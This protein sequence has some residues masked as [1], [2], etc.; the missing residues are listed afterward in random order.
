MQ[1]GSL[2]AQLDDNS[3]AKEMSQKSHHNLG[4]AYL[5]INNNST[6]HFPYYCDI[7]CPIFFPLFFGERHIG[8]SKC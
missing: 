4:S 8:G 1:D 2:D 6:V 3:C 5:Q 7:D